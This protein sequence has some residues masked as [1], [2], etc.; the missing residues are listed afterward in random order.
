MVAVAEYASR[1]PAVGCLMPNNQEFR[2]PKAL[3]RFDIAEC[4]IALFNRTKA[5]DRVNL[6]AAGR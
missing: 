2:F 6:E 3:F 5:F 4:L 1:T